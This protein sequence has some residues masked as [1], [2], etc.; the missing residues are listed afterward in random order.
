MNLPKIKIVTYNPELETRS[1]LVKKAAN[2]Q[3]NKKELPNQKVVCLN[4]P[5]AAW[6]QNENA[7]MCYCRMNY[8]YVWTKN[9]PSNFEECDA[10][11]ET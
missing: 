11:K 6:Q 4:C 1:L 2:D 7:I 3:N 5:K 8:T 10:S 9:E